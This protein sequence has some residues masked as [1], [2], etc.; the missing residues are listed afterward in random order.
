MCVCVCMCVV[1]GGVGIGGGSGGEV[2]IVDGTAVLRASI[3]E[4]EWEEN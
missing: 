1:E 2:S 3:C 4:R